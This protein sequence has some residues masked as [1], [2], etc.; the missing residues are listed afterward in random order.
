MRSIFSRKVPRLKL[1]VDYAQQ[2]ISQGDSCGFVMPNLPL[3][4]WEEILRFA[5]KGGSKVVR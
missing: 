4:S 3:V 5:T 2:M 1:G